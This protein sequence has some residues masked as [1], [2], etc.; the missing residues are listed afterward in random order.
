MGIVSTTTF[1]QKT[2]DETKTV[3]MSSQGDDTNDG[4]TPEKPCQSHAT[5]ITLATAKSPGLN[6]QVI[7][8]HVGQGN[9]DESITAPDNVRFH[10]PHVSLR[11]AVASPLITTGFAGY[12]RFDALQNTVGNGVVINNNNLVNFAST[13]IDVQG[14]ALTYSGTSCDG[15]VKVDIIQGG[16][17]GILNSASTANDCLRVECESI[18]TNDDNGIAVQSTGSAVTDI[19][20]DYLGEDPFSSNTATVGIQG[21]SGSIRI[22][23]NNVEADTAITVAN[24]GT[25]NLITNRVAGDITVASGGTLNIFATTHPSGTVTNNGTINGFIAG[26]AYGSFVFNETPRLNDIE[27]NW[28]LRYEF[29]TSTTAGAADNKFRVNNADRELATFLY[30]DLLSSSGSIRADEFYLQFDGWIFIQSVDDPTEFILY[31]VTDPITQV[32]GATGYMQIP[33][34]S[35]RDTGTQFSTDETC[36]FQFVSRSINRKTVVVSFASDLIDHVK[37]DQDVANQTIARIQVPNDE[38]EIDTCEVNYYTS[39]V[40]TGTMFI[41][42]EDDT[43]VYWN[44]SFANSVDEENV[45]NLGAISVVP[46]DSGSPLNLRVLASV[47]SATASREGRIGWIRFSGRVR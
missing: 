28:A 46:A 11:R 6:D 33:V 2:P 30:I 34:V 8:I 43:N 10:E 20:C 29:E 47:T 38:M 25:V 23:A 12:Y 44:T 36:R 42:V 45:E 1:D 14:T 32:G 21:D 19:I 9:Y 17:I 22:L 41:S 18:R 31:E 27:N 16:T 40:N 3:Y 4:D 37:V 15:T 24:G 39:E 5:A 7:V 35:R 26:T 13:T